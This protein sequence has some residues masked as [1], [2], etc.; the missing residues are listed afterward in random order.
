L[1][2]ARIAL[3]LQLCLLAGIAAAQ[4]PEQEMAAEAKKL[5]DT[6]FTKGGEHHFS[7]RILIF[8][9]KTRTA[10]VIGQYKKLVAHAKLY[11]L[12]KADPLN[13]IEW[14]AVVQFTASVGREFPHGEQF[15][16]RGLNP[17][18]LDVWS[19]WKEPQLGPYAYPIE[20]KN[21]VITIKRR[22]PMEITGI[23]CNEAPR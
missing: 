20:K 7:K 12:S 10:Y 11:P 3:L 22:P 23:N 4:S 21:G 5:L 15:V 17:K 18:K 9:Y 6:L 19:E 13:G 16:K 14:K 2:P 1:T 8:K